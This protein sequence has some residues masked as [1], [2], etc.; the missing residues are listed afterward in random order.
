MAGV[1]VRGGD[2]EG[3]IGTGGGVVG[4]MLGKGMWLFGVLGNGGDAGD[5]VEGCSFE[6]E[7]V[8]L[9]GNECWVE[10]K[11]VVVRDWRVYFGRTGRYLGN[12]DDW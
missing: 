6:A 1:V 3:G 11:R 10:Y 8:E 12:A 2:K 4:H 9:L 7:E 5:L